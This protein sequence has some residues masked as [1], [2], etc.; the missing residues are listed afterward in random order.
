MVFFSNLI[1]RRFLFFTFFSIFAWSV[2]LLKK[3]K[4]GKKKHLIHRPLTNKPNWQRERQTREK[5]RPDVNIKTKQT[6]GQT[7]KGRH[8]ERI[9]R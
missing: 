5:D 3:H 9:E 6:V 7:D 4:I 2:L 8:T 1:H